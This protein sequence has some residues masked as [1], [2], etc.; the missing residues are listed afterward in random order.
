MAIDSE[1]NLIRA[2]DEPNDLGKALGTDK[3]KGGHESGPNRDTGGVHGRDKGEHEAGPDR[4]TGGKHGRD[5]GEHEAGPDRDTG[6]KHGRD[7]GES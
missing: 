6:G 1:P 5:V 3:D 2:I 7:V 4:D